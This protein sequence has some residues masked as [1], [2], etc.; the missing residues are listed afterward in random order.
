MNGNSKL[1]LA[2]LLVLLAVVGSANSQ[3]WNVGLTEVKYG[4]W[5]EGS[6]IAC[7]G[8]YAYLGTTGIFQ[9]GSRGVSVID[10]AEPGDPMEVAFYT[11]MAGI[12]DIETAG[13]YAYVADQGLTLHVLN[14][15]NPLNPTLVQAFIYPPPFLT[16]T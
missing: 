5:V 7:Q 8:N 9:T 14:I 12:S 16:L 3:G 1:N 2:I 11:I 6:A 15:S 10:L 13:S 4:N